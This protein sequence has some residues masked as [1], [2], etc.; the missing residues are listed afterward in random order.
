MCFSKAGVVV[1]PL[2]QD[3][4][5]AAASAAGGIRMIITCLRLL[6]ATVIEMCPSAYVHM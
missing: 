2:L 1:L 5:D 6:E 3:P 4:C